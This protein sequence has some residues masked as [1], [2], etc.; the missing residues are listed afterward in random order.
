MASAATSL[1]EGG[2]NRRRLQVQYR[3]S[4]SSGSP[5][6]S[7]MLSRH[8]ILVLVTFLD[9]RDEAIAQELGV[10]SLLPKWR[11][12]PGCAVEDGD[13]RALQFI[14]QEAHYSCDR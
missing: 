14:G 2:R 8:R 4:Q 5:T 12:C 7:D 3:Y 6:S 9:V 11:Q 13:Y 10:V 1:N